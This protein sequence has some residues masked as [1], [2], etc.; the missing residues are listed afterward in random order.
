MGS[1]SPYTPKEGAPARRKSAARE[2]NCRV[3]VGARGKRSMRAGVA[4]LSPDELR[5]NTGR[6][7]REGKDF[8]V[9]IRYTDIRTLHADGHAGTL[10]V[11]TNEDEEIVFHLGRLAA[12]WKQLIEARPSRLDELGVRPTSRVALIGVDDDELVTEI[13]ARVPG[14]APAETGD[15]LDVLFVGVE[16]RADLARL[17]QFAARV[18]RQLGVIWAIFPTA[19]RGVS[20]AEIT[21]AARPAGLVPTRT[22][23]FGG[24]R[25]ALGLM[26]A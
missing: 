3:Q 15:E 22:L 13:A 10:T 4:V 23:E 7:G 12:E 26:R 19:E 17:G 21:A 6:T 11:V 8:F 20:A 1:R 2:T 24:E 14:F 5:F 9:H 16:H 25:T 18:R